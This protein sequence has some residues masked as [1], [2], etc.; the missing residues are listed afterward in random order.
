M[1]API[2]PTP[3]PS[4]PT[5]A[6]RGAD[7]PATAA[8]SGERDGGSGDDS[9]Q[10]LLEDLF[11]TIHRLQV[12]RS[13]DEVW[14]AGVCGGFAQR[15]RIDP[16]VVRV[17]LIM[18]T[19][20]S[21]LGI[22]AYLV[23]WMLLP[24][25]DRPSVAE[26]AM[27]RHGY[28]WA[29]VA[30][31]IAVPALA[32][33]LVVGSGSRVDFGGGFLFP[34]WLVVPALVGIALYWRG[35]RRI[36]PAPPVSGSAPI[37]APW[38]PDTTATPATAW[39]PGTTATAWGPGTPATAWGYGTPATPW[40]PGTPATPW[41]P[42]TTAT[43]WGPGTPATATPATAWAP[44]SAGPSNPAAA[45]P[46][47]GRPGP[48]R[49]SSRRVLATRRRRRPRAHPLVA[50]VT[51]GAA[52]ATYGLV[53]VLHNHSTLAGK[54]LAVA[55]G[56]ALALVAVVL[57]GIGLSGRTGGLTSFLGW[58]LALA[59]AIAAGGTTSTW[60]DGVGDRVWI[61]SDLSR[62]SY[63]LGLGDATL[64]LSNLVRPT[65]AT[66][67]QISVRL[68]AGSLR[69]DIPADLTVTVNANVRFGEID[70]N[71]TVTS[72]TSDGKAVSRVT[73]QGD[74]SADLVVNA[75][76]EFGELIIRKASS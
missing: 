4:E 63:S 70:D 62:T 76:V 50:L 43:P 10:R 54:G 17:G 27:A 18:L 2:P 37:D 47:T 64:D 22:V 8:G 1:T 49:P 38:G 6:V 42:G 12:W 71:G 14:L 19:M 48:G 9:A 15:V 72:T 68:D 35:R 74:G 3:A 57:V 60:R 66:A 16:V 65:T 28:S 30:A 53:L 21:G 51:A 20:F 5:T 31:L 40:G 23:G 61:P 24:H 75:N 59:T 39:G 11:E 52:L 36:E 46:S 44:S 73:S 69:I 41:G 7:F 67:P 26:K 25:V 33:V 55:L 58:S 45:T 32:L 29:S 56:A 34:G 13:R